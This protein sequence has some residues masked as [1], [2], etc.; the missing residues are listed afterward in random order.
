L[1]TGSTVA[2]VALTT[3][4]VNGKKKKSFNI[5][6]ASDLQD[7]LEP[8]QYPWNHAH[9]WESFDHASIRR[10][11]F[12]YYTIGKACHAMD[13]VHYRHLVNVAI[14]EK[15]AKELAQAEQFPDK[16]NDEGEIV[17]R[18]GA[19]TD[20]LPNPYQNEQ[21]ARFMNNGASPPDLSLIVKARHGN[22]DY[23]MAL[24]TGYRD[25]PAGVKVA[26]NMYYNPYFPGGQ[27]SMPPPL[28]EGAVEYDDGTE[29]SISQM[30]KDVTTYLTWASYPELDD[31]HSMGMK[32]FALLFALTLPLFYYKRFLWSTIKNRKVA[33]LRRTQS[34][35]DKR[36]KNF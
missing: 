4:W 23:V 10:G 1:I 12:V 8:P 14:T 32:A 33:F 17:T 35:I 2:T 28:S 18:P 6:K 11:F 19:L 29:A 13:Y 5:A 16:P 34:Y 31:R 20:P 36:R 24:L 7:H 30:A 3:F 25:P 9:L 15:E 26:E 22:E 27:L 21:Q